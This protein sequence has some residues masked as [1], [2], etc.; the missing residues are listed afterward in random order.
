M[1]ASLVMHGRI[2]VITLDNPPVNGLGYETRSQFS[3]ALDRA[4]A[5]FGGAWFDRLRM[6]PEMHT[7]TTASTTL[8]VSQGPALARMRWAMARSTRRPAAEPCRSSCPS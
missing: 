2:A 7:S 8:S 1:G 3:A 6:T 5:G 4:A